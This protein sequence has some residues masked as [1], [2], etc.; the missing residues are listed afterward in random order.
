MCFF[1]LMSQGSFN[2]KIRFLGQKV[3]PVAHSRTDTHTQTEWLLRAPFQGFRIFSFNLIGPT[4]HSKHCIMINTTHHSI[5][6]ILLRQSEPQGTTPIALS[7][8]DVVQSHCILLILFDLFLRDT[9]VECPLINEGEVITMFNNHDWRKS[10]WK[11]GELAW[12]M[13]ISFWID[14]IAFWINSATTF[15]PLFNN[16]TS[17]TLLTFR[18]LALLLNRFTIITTQSEGIDNWV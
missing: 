12:Y 5:M 6:S 15:T 16:S 13:L 8:L 10:H 18:L 11:D 14:N 4:D 7:S 1:F 3:C 9:E 2:T 17:I